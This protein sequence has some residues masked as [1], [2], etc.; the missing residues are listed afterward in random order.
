MKSHLLWLLGTAAISANAQTVYKMQPVAIQSRW[1]KE[2]SPQNALKDYPRPQMVRTGWT[3]LNGLWDYAISPKDAGQPAAFEG[4]ILVPYPIES[5]LSGVKKTLLPTQTLWY[6]RNIN[7]SPKTG[8]RILL[9]FGAVDW[10]ATIFVNGKEV[11]QH[12]GGYTA[13]SFDVTD[14]LRSGSNELAVKVFDPTDQGIGPHGKQVLNPQN[15]YYTPSS[16]I[17]QTVWLETV[18]EIYIEGL[19]MTPDIDKGVLNLEVKSVSAAPVTTVVDGKTFKGKANERI[20]V[21]IANMKLWSPAS[22]YLYNLA[23][24]L[25]KDEVKSYFGMRKVSIGKDAKGVDRIFLNN[26]PY[27]NLGTL[28]Q[29]FWPEGLYTAPTDEALSFDIKAIKAMGF[30]TIRKHIKVEPAR[31][32]YWADKL[33]MLVWQDFV[34]PNQSLPEGSKAEF[35]KGAL[36]EMTQLH[37]SPCVVAWVLF[38]EKWGQYDQQRLSEWVKKTDPSRILNGHSGEL[39]YVNEQL[40]SPSPNAY[41]SADMT[42]VHSYP[43]PMMSIRQAGKAQVC[44]E[45]GGIGVFIPDHQWI[46]GSAW[47]YIQEKPAALKAKYTIMNQHLQLMEKEGLSGSIYTQ[48]FDVEGEQNGLMTYDR[49]VIKI[50]FEEMREIHSQLNP[51]LSTSSWL[52]MTRDV[53]AK[54]ADLMEPGIAYS[55]MLKEYINGKRD[56]PFLKKMAMMAMQAGDKP[57]A[58]L[59]GSAY[60]SSLKMP[61]SDEDI[62]SVV[63]FTKSTKDAGF[64]LMNINAE[65][66]KKVM[67][68]RKYTV[69]MMNMILKGE[70]EPLMTQ[71]NT[72]WSV[73]EAR[74]KPYGAP[75][76]EILLRAKTVGF[77]NQ[78]DWA[79]YVP[80]ARAYLEKFGAN[81]PEQERSMFQGAIDQHK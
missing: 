71:G 63:Q 73:I 58:L 20:V 22:P 28:D 61:L 16:G 30:N 80:A 81:I 21:P 23:I 60:V 62:N 3:N 6:K 39:L 53:S 24:K 33:G 34:N 52:A 42:D 44:G 43:D 4:Q 14:A 67:G 78:Q 5:A 77:Y 12:K 8:E 11:G 9:H 57:G 79:N 18:P 19:V 25:G 35:E 50:P 75:G 7:L 10:Q 68:D 51:D 70:M 38:N 37:N 74:V 72:D 54:D 48:P 36:D 29:G 46:I 26:K 66:F 40:R 45:F 17:W 1:A 49:E 32:Y 59:A 64:T 55:A 2:V 56:L 47:G 76:E 41:V 15:I 13:F 69:A 31:W 27:Y 65:S